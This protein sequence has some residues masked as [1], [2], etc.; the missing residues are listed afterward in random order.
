MSTSTPSSPFTHQ[1]KQQSHNNNGVSPLML[2]RSSSN[3]SQSLQ[4]SKKSMS[5]SP[6]S[7]SSSST[8]S[9]SRSSS[10]T[11]S[12]TSTLPSSQC[13]IPRCVVCIRGAPVSFEKST[14]IWSQILHV[15]LYALAEAAKYSNTHRANSD[16]ATGK[17]YFH[18]RDDIYDFINIHW[19]IIC[20]RE[21]IPHWKHTIG[22]TLSHY[23]NLFQNGYQ[24]FQNT[25]YWCLKD[26]SIDPYNLDE[27]DNKR[28]RVNKTDSPSL[29]S[30]SLSSPSLTS[31]STASSALSSA[32]TASITSSPSSSFPFS[33][34]RKP[35]DNQP[36][37]FPNKYLPTTTNNMNNNNNNLL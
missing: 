37:H 25:G 20:R 31:S 22:M 29:S 11:S 12:S 23:S 5:M 32:S 7:S 24:I 14:P 6:M 21:K 28:R 13:R 26:T 36:R 35:R 17:R 27:N 4:P 1:S 10:S 15:V 9:S 33:I 34:H 2:G 16:L 3:S 30:P 19:D 18:L 8:T